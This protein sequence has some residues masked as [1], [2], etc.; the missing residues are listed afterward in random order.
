[1]TFKDL[2]YIKIKIVNPL[3]L[4]I[5]KKNGYIEESNQNKYFKVVSADENRE[6]WKYMKNCGVKSKIWLG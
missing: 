1:M 2:R 4:I 5:G 3:Y 6:I